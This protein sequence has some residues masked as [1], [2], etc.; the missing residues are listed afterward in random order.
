MNEEP[1][2]P[3]NYYILTERAERDGKRGTVKVKKWF[4]DKEKK[5]VEKEIW[6]KEDR[7]AI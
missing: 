7:D 1:F 4:D 5:Y 2:D 3:A 6:F